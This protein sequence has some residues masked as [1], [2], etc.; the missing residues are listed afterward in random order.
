M[1]LQSYRQ[2]LRREAL[3]VLCFLGQRIIIPD[4]LL[5]LDGQHRRVLRMAGE[6]VER[7]DEMASSDS[8]QM[9]IYLHFLANGLAAE[10]LDFVEIVCGEAAC[11]NNQSVSA[12]LDWTGQRFTSNFQIHISIF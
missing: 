3:Q 12:R 11:G 8:L 6:Q 1:A 2:Y 4:R 7:E 5:F 10:V 9:V